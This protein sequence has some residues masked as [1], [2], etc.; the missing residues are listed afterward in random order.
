MLKFEFLFFVLNKNTGFYVY[1]FELVDLRKAGLGRYFCFLFTVDYII[2]NWIELFYF[3]F[4]YFL[5]SK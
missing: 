1:V 5:S 3:I 2:F 4:T